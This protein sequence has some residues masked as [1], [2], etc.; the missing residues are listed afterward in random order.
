MINK[1]KKVYEDEFI[2]IFFIEQKPKTKRYS[3]WSKCSDCKLGEIRWYPP[4]RHYCFIIKDLVFSDRCQLNLGEF[5]RKLNEEHKDQ[6]K[7][8][9]AK[10]K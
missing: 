2:K 1:N 6:I 8:L 10:I 5:T 7:S 4:W 3:V 9:R